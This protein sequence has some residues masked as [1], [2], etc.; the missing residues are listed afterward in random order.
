MPKKF[1]SDLVIYDI[2][3]RFLPTTSEGIALSYMKNHP[4]SKPARDLFVQ[5][6]LAHW[7]PF[8]LAARGVE[9]EALSL[10]CF[11]AIGELE[12]HINLIRRVVLAQETV[13]TAHIEVPK[14]TAFAKSEVTKLSL[15]TA[16]SDDEVPSSQRKNLT[17][18]KKVS[19]LF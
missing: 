16:A 18:P 10:A 15:D 5:T 12:K 7:L 14:K 11:E 13:I 8:G 4:S 3:L 19:D 9:G 2:R 17:V 6:M 1:E